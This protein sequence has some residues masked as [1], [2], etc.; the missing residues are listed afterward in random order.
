MKPS[1]K[2][3]TGTTGAVVETRHALI[4]NITDD[5]QCCYMWR[6]QTLRFRHQFCASAV[7]LWIEVCHHLNII[8]SLRQ[9]IATSEQNGMKANDMPHLSE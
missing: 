7:D 2:G 6:P 4:D 9:D 5:Q 8:T 3:Q 1:S